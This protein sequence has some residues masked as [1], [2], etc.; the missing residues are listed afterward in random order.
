MWK[1]LS[2]NTAKS[3]VS[4]KLKRFSDS[5]S[6][7]NIL[8]LIPWLTFGGAEIVN[9]EILDSLKKDRWNIFIVTTKEASHEWEDKFRVYTK[10]I[11]HIE[12]LPQRLHTYIFL[13]LIRRYS[14]DVVF[15]SNSFTGYLST[16]HLAELATVVDLV[17]SEGGEE[18][19]G[20]TPAFS[21]TFDKYIKKRIVISDRLKQL[22]INKYAINPDKIVV[23]R[24]G[25]DL[26][27]NNELYDVVTDEKLEG[28][29]RR[30]RI[31]CW[32]ARVSSEKQP[33][34]LIEL[35]KKMTEF[36]FLLIG[37][38]NLLEDVKRSSLGLDNFYVTGALSNT[39]TKKL[40]SISDVLVLTSQFEGVPM[41][42]LE[43]MSLGIPVVS[44]NVGAIKEIIDDKVDGFLC[45]P[46]RIQADMPDM[47]NRA[48]AERNEIGNKSIQ[49]IRT[50]FSKNIMQSEYLKLFNE[51]V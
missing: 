41:V 22:Y 40:I 39:L 27:P 8:F 33:L 23:I 35:A 49:K 37:D 21:S 43:A 6:G 30:E 19:K 16:P 13:E 38:G 10:N 18:D 24:N 20:G 44:T 9:L 1:F 34:E 17:H 15:I 42:I 47:I 48:Y 28:F 2:E 31:V 26:S 46:K 32:V 14:I 51:L 7:K 36:N 50:K 29:M 45:D 25:V 12:N 11:L 5:N 4:F 3:Y